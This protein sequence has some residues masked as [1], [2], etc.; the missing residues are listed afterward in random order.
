MVHQWCLFAAWVN[1]HVGFTLHIPGSERLS[2]SDWWWDV[3]L[4]G[5]ATT[6]IAT[7][8]AVWLVIRTLR[9]DRETAQETEIL[10][11]CRA[12]LANTQEVMR[13]FEE[14]DRP[15]GL[16]FDSMGQ[17]LRGLRSL[18]NQVQ[19]REPKMSELLTELIYSASNSHVEPANVDEQRFKHAAGGVETVLLNRV[20]Y[21][22]ALWK[23]MSPE[24]FDQQVLRARGSIDFIDVSPVT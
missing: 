7:G 6:G 21:G 11:S 16:T 14:A 2:S 20:A 24:R 18:C 10:A 3:A 15:G 23:S 19:A 22:P 9:H 4:D 12:S 13:A 17:W 5:I 8:I 1:A